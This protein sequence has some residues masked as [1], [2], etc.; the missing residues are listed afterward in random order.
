MEDRTEYFTAAIQERDQYWN[1]EIATDDIGT[2]L[3]LRGEM[4]HDQGA[5]IPG[6]IN[7]PYNSATCVPGPYIVPHFD[8]RVRIV[9]TNK[10]PCSPVRARAAPRGFC[11]GENGRCNGEAGLRSSRSKASQLNSRR[12]NAL[13]YPLTNRMEHLPPMT[14]VIIQR[15]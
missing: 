4:I 11:N 6:G 2:I 8:L 5:Y 1:M 7:L 3:G 12:T 9:H 13:H 10:V 15:L 14:P